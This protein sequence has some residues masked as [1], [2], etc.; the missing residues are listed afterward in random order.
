MSRF[1]AYPFERQRAVW[2][3]VRCVMVRCVYPIPNSATLPWC[4]FSVAAGI[5]LSRRIGSILPGGASCR[6]RR[7]FHIQSCH[8]GRQDAV[9][10]VT[11]DG[12][13][14]SR[15]PAVRR[16]VPLAYRTIPG[17]IELGESSG[18]YV[19]SGVRPC[20]GA[21]TRGNDVVLEK[22]D[23]FEPVEPAAAEDS[24][25]PVNRSSGGD[26]GVPKLQ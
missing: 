6:R 20:S 15:K 1:S 21:E 9:L 3:I 13:R 10:Y 22:S 25:S 8:S 18:G 23:G 26:G 14:Y 16:T 5:A 12:C 19:F 11:Q 4:V 7:Q 2:A 17:T 24:R